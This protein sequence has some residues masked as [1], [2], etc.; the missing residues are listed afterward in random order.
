MSAKLGAFRNLFGNIA[1]LD[2]DK[3]MKNV[4]NNDQ[5][6]QQDILDLNRIDQLYDRGINTDGNLLIASGIDGGYARNTIVGT[7]EYKGKIALGLPT[8]HVTLFNEGIFYSTF[9]L[10]VEATEAFITADTIKDGVDISDRYADGKA[11]GLTEESKRKM[12]GWVKVPFVNEMRK[13]IFK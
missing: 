11:L 5:G 3:L 8:N 6:L 13:A 2:G 10:D 7:N 12:I 4:L 1:K 9:K